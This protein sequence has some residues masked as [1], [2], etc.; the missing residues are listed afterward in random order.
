M[1][2]LAS[3]YAGAPLGPGALEIPGPALE[4]RD[5]AS[6]AAAAVREGCTG[7]TVSALVAE[8][9]AEQAEDPE[10]RRVLRRIAAEET[11]HAEL[12][13]RFVA[14]ALE[15]GGA[16]VRAAVAAAFAEPP[17][18]PVQAWPSEVEAVLRAHGRLSPRERRTIADSAFT[19][20]IGP[21]ARALL[22]RRADVIGVAA[23]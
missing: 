14:W 16:D 17:S 15:R 5:L 11:R 6:I 1:C 13:F 23:A 4:R 22:H 12:S 10:A 20:V 21:C 8:A 18:V 19:E 2:A 7:E 3:R 9:A